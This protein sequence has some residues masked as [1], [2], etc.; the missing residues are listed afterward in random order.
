M[1]ED[2]FRVKLGDLMGEVVDA[3]K[4]SDYDV[5]RILVEVAISAIDGH[6][7]VEDNTAVVRKLQNALDT[8]KQSKRLQRFK[9][10]LRPRAQALLNVIAGAQASGAND[11][12][13]SVGA[14]VMPCPSAV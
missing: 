10:G 14:S 1:S 5:V 2:Y 9:Q 6:G 11:A 4:M 12:Q 13:P 8:L 7:I 3:G